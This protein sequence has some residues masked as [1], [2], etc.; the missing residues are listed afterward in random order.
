M[1]LSSKFTFSLIA[2]TA[3]LVFGSGLMTQDAH[4]ASMGS[5][6]TKYPPHLH[7]EIKIE[8]NSG[9]PIIV[10][11]SDMNIENIKSNIGDTINVTVSIGD[12]TYLWNI[13][14]S[15]FITNYAPEPSSMN[16]YFRTN[17]DDYN[18]VGLSVYEWYQTRDDIKYDYDGTISWNEPI[19]EIKPRTE[20]YHAYEGPLLIGEKEL[21]VTYSMNMNKEMPQTQTGL[22]IADVDN[23]RS[24]F[25]LPFTLEVLPNDTI[26][27]TEPTEEPTEEP[28]EES[29][30]L[31]SELVEITLVSNSNSYENGDK[32]IITG[33][34]QNYDLNSMMGQ[35]ILYDVISPENV[36]L[37][38]GHI[39]PNSDGS[40]YFTTFAMDTM[41]KTDGNYVFSVNIR[42]LEQTIDI[43]YDNTQFET[44]IPESEII[45]APII[46][47]ATPEATP[48]ASTSNIICGTG[49]EDVNGICQVIQIEETSSNGGG[50]L[51]ATATYGSEMAP[52]VQQ[53]RELR[54]NQLLQ[55]ESG[56]AFMGT[57]ND[58][59]YSFSPIIADY[60][61]ENPYFKEAVKLA[62]TPMISSLSL[63]ENAESESEV[64]GIGISVIMLNIGMYLGVPAVVVVGIKK[65]K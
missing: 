20:T 18:Q 8:I 41:W 24:D 23:N 35:D 34:I 2:I 57:F 65:I 43:S 38:S 9:A 58:I 42:S 61:R 53:L 29:S 1:M 10:H 55:T 62:I 21:L 26:T 25:I 59:Y 5:N 64:L 39:G 19:T 30:S 47:E 16:N 33:Q 49:T 63:M 52:Q 27:I 6:L 44:P 45:D 7:D 37:S 3:L 56:T 50:C 28:A 14:E 60:E 4:A 31:E 40:F 32:V 13:G 51:I 12:D 54:D 36:V 46:P 11:I 22:K 15:K 17:Y 48:E